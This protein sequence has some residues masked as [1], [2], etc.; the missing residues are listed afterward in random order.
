MSLLGNLY[1]FSEVYKVKQNEEL[2]AWNHLHNYTN[3]F[4]QVT[5]N[6]QNVIEDPNNNDAYLWMISSTDY[7][8]TNSPSNYVSE[9]LSFYLVTLS[10]Q[11]NAIVMEY[12]YHNE[13]STLTSEQLEYVKEF[14]ENLQILSSE[15]NGMYVKNV[16]TNVSLRQFE[17]ELVIKMEDIEEKNQE[18][19]NNIPP[20]ER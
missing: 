9:D 6:M 4:Q 8:R 19:L 1:A 16:S 12:F 17:K 7:L 5:L 15:F 11:V 10:Q 20:V 18:I 3:H 13:V 14:N 2:K